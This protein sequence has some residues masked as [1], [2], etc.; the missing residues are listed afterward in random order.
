MSLKV[1][2][3]TENTENIGARDAFHVPGVFVISKKRITP[4]D[5]LRFISGK[6]VEPCERKRRHAIADPFIPSTI[7][8]GSGFYA[9]VVPEVVGAVSHHFAIAGVPGDEGVSSD[10]VAKLKAENLRLSAELEEVRDELE[11]AQGYDDGCRG[12]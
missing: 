3:V 11:D 6:E 1:G 9:M 4:G 2:Q 5:N 7:F 8:P 12:C 10:E